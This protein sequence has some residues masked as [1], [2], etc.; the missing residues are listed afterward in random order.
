MNFQKRAALV[1]A[2]GGEEELH[3]VR[4][5]VFERGAQAFHA[6]LGALRAAGDV[7]AEEIRVAQPDHLVAAEHRD[8]LQRLDGGRA[9][10]E[11]GVRVV[12]DA[13]DGFVGETIVDAAGELVVELE[14]FFADHALI[15]ADHREEVSGVRG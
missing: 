13:V 11:G 3:A 1:H 14:G 12:R 9:D 7:V 5:T 4:Q 6:G 2:L 15:A 10:L 8:G